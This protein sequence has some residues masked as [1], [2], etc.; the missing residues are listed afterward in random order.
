VRIARLARGGPRTAVFAAV[1]AALPVASGCRY[2]ASP[3]HTGLAE[4]EMIELVRGELDRSMR[5]EEAWAQCDRLHLWARRESL[6]VPGRRNYFHLKAA[7][8]PPGT[9]S[10]WS[11]GSWGALLLGFDDNGFLD[12]AAYLPPFDE[13]GNDNSQ[14]QIELG[15]PTP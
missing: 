1:A 6:L 15:E 14:L 9:S 2:N 11:Y 12:G 10:L 4:S 8:Y 13:R 7:V 5:L 3:V